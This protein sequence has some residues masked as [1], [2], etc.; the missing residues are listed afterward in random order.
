MGLFRHTKTQCME[1]E[2]QKDVTL[3][4]FSK[5]FE[6]ALWKAE[7]KLDD[8]V[9]ALKIGR[10]EDSE[11][12]S[13]RSYDTWS[14]KI[15]SDDSKSSRERQREQSN[16]EINEWA[17]EFGA[18]IAEVPSLSFEKQQEQSEKE[19]NELTSEPVATEAKT[20][21]FRIDEDGRLRAV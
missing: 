6:E 14:D 18:S 17:S 19:T 7:Q 12:G 11:S 4:E 3:R 10:D 8:I 13:E 20:I 16:E 1:C 5:K 21:L 15:C 9:Q 2:Y